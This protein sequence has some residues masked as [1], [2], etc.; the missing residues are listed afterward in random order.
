[1]FC[2]IYSWLIEKEVDDE[3]DVRSAFLRRHLMRCPRCRASYQQLQ[4]LSEQ[5]RVSPPVSDEALCCR[6]QRR[7]RQ[8]L[9][10]DGGRPA[11]AIRFRQRTFRPAAIGA[12]AAAVLIVGVFSGI[13]MRSNHRPEPALEFPVWDTTSL[14][15]KASA[16]LQFPVQ[17]VQD[18][19][20][21][22]RLD[23]KQALLSLKRCTPYAFDEA[24]ET[25][26]E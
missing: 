23:F 21:N 18:E 19:M 26:N 11:A 12:A 4:R 5:L 17:S 8:R 16:V 22:L 2:R 20:T 14:Q 6:I 24:G 15:A 9:A 3:G 1:M 7:I 10:E 25:P 13:W